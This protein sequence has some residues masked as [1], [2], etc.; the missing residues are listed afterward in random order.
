MV[1][2][3]GL[4]ERKYLRSSRKITELSSTGPG[5]A[6]GDTVSLVHLLCCLHFCDLPSSHKGTHLTRFNFWLHRRGVL[7]L[8]TY[9]AHYLQFGSQLK[10]TISQTLHLNCP[11]PFTYKSSISAMVLWSLKNMD[12]ECVKN[13]NPIYARGKCRDC[14]W[15]E[16]YT[17]VAKITPLNTRLLNEF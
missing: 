11:L 9:I 8:S 5:L 3:A 10:A 13:L 17:V 4:G 1:N 14:F 15:L 12:V 16:T 6:C 2:L 7:H